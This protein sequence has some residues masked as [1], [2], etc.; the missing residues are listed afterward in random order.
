MRVKSLGPD[1]PNVAENFGSLAELQAAMGQWADSPQLRPIAA[2]Y[3]PTCGASLPSLSP[4]EQ[5]AFLQANNESKFQGSLS[6]GLQRRSDPEIVTISTN[7]LLNGKGVA[8]EALCRMHNWPATAPIL[9]LQKLPNSCYKCDSN[10]P[11]W[12]MLHRSRADS[13]NA[14][15]NWTNCNSRKP[16]CA[17]NCASARRSVPGGSMD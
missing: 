3:S 4:A 10:W 2:N 15:C 17:E 12:F 14:N 16:T 1:D 11:R 8:Q 6:L 13:R 9:T 7:W 5:T